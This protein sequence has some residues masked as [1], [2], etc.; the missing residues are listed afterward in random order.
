MNPGRWTLA[1]AAFSKAIDTSA[2]ASVLSKLHLSRIGFSHKSN[3][4]L[5]LSQ[6]ILYTMNWALFHI[7][8][9]YAQR[10]TK[11]LH[12]QCQLKVLNLTKLPSGGIRNFGGLS[13]K[14]PQLQ[15]FMELP[16][17]S[18][19]I[20]TLIKKKVLLDFSPSSKFPTLCAY[21]CYSLRQSCC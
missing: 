13:P 21:N 9:S 15:K 12:K 20:G 17:Y 6:H 16:V 4:S 18:S 10:S 1:S 2:D 19:A 11:H 8:T 7:P 3:Q 5:S 14:C